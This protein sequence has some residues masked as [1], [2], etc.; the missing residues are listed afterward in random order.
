MRCPNIPI[1]YY[2]PEVQKHTAH[3][4]HTPDKKAGNIIFLPAGVHLIVAM[5]VYR[6]AVQ[7]IALIQAKS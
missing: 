6:T 2:M 4:Y 1:E 7:Q 3:T 5:K